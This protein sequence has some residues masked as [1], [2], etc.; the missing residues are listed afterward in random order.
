MTNNA[1]KTPSTIV[2]AALYHF[3]RLPDFHA[4]QAPLLECCR[5]NNLFGTLL[6]ADEGINGTVAGT[7]EG[8]DNVLAFLRAEPRLADLVHKESCSQTLPFH[9]MKVRLKKEIVTMGVPG[10]DPERIKGTYLDAQQW[11][12]MIRDPDVLVIDT[13]NDYEVSIGTFKNATSPNTQTFREFPD[14]VDKNL[15]D[16][17]DRK[18]AMF[19]TGGIRCEKSTSYLK[20]QGFDNVYHLQGGIL[21]YLETVAPEDNLWEGECFVFDSRVSVDKNLAPGKYDQCFACRRPLS[22]LDKTLADYQP[23]VS[24]AY[25]INEYSDT[26]RKRFTERQKQ[27]QLAKKRGETHIGQAQPGADQDDK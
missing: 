18:I 19:C 3:A 13:R 10:T 23:G 11:N 5:N 16:K 2:V 1:A 21:K 7:R 14:Y 9:R 4:L 24:C 26:Q 20:D 12:A 15:A 8:I 6:L 27:V 25:C 17:K 22:E